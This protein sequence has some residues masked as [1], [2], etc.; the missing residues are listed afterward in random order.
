MSIVIT[1]AFF[2]T[3]INL[4]MIQNLKNF[5]RPNFGDILHLDIS[6]HL[7]ALDVVESLPVQTL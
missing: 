3:L 2:R 5:K 7:T 6:R 1:S 4:N